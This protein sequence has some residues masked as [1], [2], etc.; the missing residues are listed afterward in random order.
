MKWTTRTAWLGLLAPL[1]AAGAPLAQKNDA[2]DAPVVQPVEPATG[3]IIT[4]KPGIAANESATHLA[5]A[6]DLQRR[7]LIKRQEEGEDLKTFD[8]FDYKGYAGVFDEETIAE[9]ESSDEVRPF[10]LRCSL[11]YVQ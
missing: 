9:I 5:W 7:G 1:L 8:L 11:T 2:H 10:L 3:Y 6:G 4:L